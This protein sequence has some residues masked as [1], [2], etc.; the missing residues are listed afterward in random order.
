MEIDAYGMSA[1]G[2]FIKQNSIP[3]LEKTIRVILEYWTRCTAPN[4]F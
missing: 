3:D 4:D 1:Q 2:F